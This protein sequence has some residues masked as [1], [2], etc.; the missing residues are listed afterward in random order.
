[1][2][3]FKL[4]GRLPAEIIFSPS[5]SYCKSL[6]IACKGQGLWD[7]VHKTL[8]NLHREK[9]LRCFCIAAVYMGVKLVSHPISR[10]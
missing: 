7:S 3:V 5:D 9:I 8:T 4:Q 2:L 1:V 10:T 6:R